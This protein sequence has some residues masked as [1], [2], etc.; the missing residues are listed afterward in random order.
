MNQ[1]RDKIKKKTTALNPKTTREGEFSKMEI[2]K[3]TQNEHEGSKNMDLLKKLRSRHKAN[4]NLKI[5]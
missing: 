2:V 4:D 5:K 3:T 1:I